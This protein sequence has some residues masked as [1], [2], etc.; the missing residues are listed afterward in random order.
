MVNFHKLNGLKNP[1]VYF[2]SFL[3]VRT[4]KC[5]YWD[6]NQS[7]SRDVFLLEALRGK[8]FLSL[9]H[10]LG[11][12]YIPWL[13][14]HFSIASSIAY[15]ILSLLWPLLL[16]SP[17]LNLTMSLLPPSQKD[18]YDYIGPTWIIRDNLPTKLYLQYPCCHV[19]KYIPKFWQLD[20]DI[21]GGPL[22]SLL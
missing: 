5:S 10:L 21:F 4:Q 8:L 16:W 9:F 15:S 1:Q 20:V 12:L 6:K 22:F 3:E 17:F 7:V 19:R 13:M 14:G 11:T 18:S 2:A